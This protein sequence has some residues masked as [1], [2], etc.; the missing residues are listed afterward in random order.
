VVLSLATLLTTAGLR[1]FLEPTLLTTL[2]SALVWIAPSLAIL[3]KVAR[4]LTTLTWLIGVVCHFSFL[5][6][7][8][9]KSNVWRRGSY[10]YLIVFLRFV[11]VARGGW[12]PVPGQRKGNDGRETQDGPDGVQVAPTFYELGSVGRSS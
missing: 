3:I 10:R 4:L 11:R 8:R 6:L 2:L 5:S 12:R 9:S 1:L 7:S